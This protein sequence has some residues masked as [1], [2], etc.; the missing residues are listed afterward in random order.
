MAASDPEII[1]LGGSLAGL[2]LALACER[3]ACP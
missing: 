1:I 2:T 3:A